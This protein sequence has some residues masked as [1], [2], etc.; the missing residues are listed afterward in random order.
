[1][2]TELARITEIAKQQKDERFNALVHLINRQT[3][4]ESHQQLANGKAVGVD[5]VTKDE[6]GSNVEANIDSLLERMKRQAYKPQ[7][8]RRVY[9]PK[10]GSTKMRPLGIPAYEDKLV[11]KTMAPILNAIYEADFLEFSFGFRPNRG[12]HD[13]LKVLGQI[14]ETRPVNY[15]VDADIKGFFDNV[16]HE[17]MMKF[18]EHRIADPNFLRLIK[19]FLM[20][21]II[22]AGVKYETPAGT[23]QGGVISPILAN[24]YLHYTLD[25]WFEKRFRQQCRGKA[26]MVRYADD[27][28]C[29]F[30]YKDDAEA[31]LPA[32]KERLAQFSLEIAE[33]KTQL[34]AFGRFAAENNEKQ[35]EDKPGTFDFLGFTHYCSKSQ[36]GKFR[37]KRKTSK[38][39]FKASLVRSKEWLHQHLTTPAKLLLE[40]LNRKLAGYYQY[41]GITDNGKALSD[42][43]YQ[44]RKQLYWWFNR[45]SQ[46]KHF[47]WRKFNLFLAKFP[48]LR[49]KIY[50]SVYDIDE[51]LLKT[52]R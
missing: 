34:L 45:R 38:K 2:D 28:V 1:M 32:L 7:P 23:P 10:P 8:A 3:L 6:Y 37:V 42:Y 48:L 11:Q 24:V 4:M 15:L 14:I 40:K 5:Q 44:L 12:C 16:S 27:F 20:S 9:I 17:W 29:C 36:H 30:Q 13:A 46:G 51:K 22:E 49:P 41:Y 31:F 35:G 39:K 50:V 21:G 33:E 26:Y 19:R 52:I 18:L 47:N 43:Q 25:L